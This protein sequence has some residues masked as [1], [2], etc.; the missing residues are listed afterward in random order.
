MRGE[1][2]PRIKIEKEETKHEKFIRLATNR[3]QS[4]LNKIKIL[5]NCSNPYQ[6][7][8]TDEDIR[9]IFKSIDKELKIIR[10]KFEGN[11]TKKFT[12]L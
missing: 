10:A 1:K 12:L 11:L 8:Y 7:E 9:K 3:T 6:Y 4:I 2:M 5:G